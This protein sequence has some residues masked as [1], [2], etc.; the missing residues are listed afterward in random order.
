MVGPKDSSKRFFVFSNGKTSGPFTS[1]QLRS[2]AQSGRLSPEDQVTKE[3][4][5]KWYA[6][7]DVKGLFDSP[8]NVSRRP[9]F[10][11]ESLQQRTAEQVLVMG[12]QKSINS[13]GIASL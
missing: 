2:L 1:E 5:G 13:L 8:L 10:A 3:S 9:A 6:A 11:A 4:G 7:Q 12:S